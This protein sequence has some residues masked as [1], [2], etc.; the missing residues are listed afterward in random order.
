MSIIKR[1]ADK[2]GIKE[3]CAFLESPWFSIMYGV[4]VFW[5]YALN[6]PIVTLGIFA[7]CG[8][9]VCLFCEDTRAG[10]TLLL[11]TIFSFRYK[12]NPQIYISTPA[13][14]LYAVAGPCLLFAIG[15]RLLKRRVPFKSRYGLLGVALFTAAMLLGGVFTEYYTFWGFA[16]ATALSAG[17]FLSYAFFAFTLKNKED[18]L[19]YLA[20]V[21]TVGVCL[22]S[23]EVFEFYL[24][25]YR[26]GSPLDGGWKGLICLG[27]AM[28]NMVSE[29]IVFAL[30]AVFYL[31]YKEDRG[32]W[33]WLVVLIALVAIYLML[34]RNALLGAVVCVCLGTLANCL[35]GKN[36]TKNRILVGLFLLLAIGGLIGLHHMGYIEDLLS[37][38]MKMGLSDNGRFS[39]WSR[40]IGFFKE[41]PIF[42]AGFDAY[43]QYSDRVSRAHNNLLQMLGSTGIV[44]LIMYLI[45]RVQTVGMI[46]KK[47]T[48]DRLLMGGCIGIS[49][50]MAMLSSTFFHIYS[51]IHYAVILLVLE[52]SGEK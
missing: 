18:N 9:F 36:R 20:R 24:R 3:L 7:V 17:L 4:V 10:I 23:L 22:I 14:I 43:K 29:M 27:W 6:I 47:P 50:M 46:L 35:T 34:G 45:H 39:V 26:W 33:Y 19:L 16:K 21:L 2:K 49:L 41:N 48:V 37:F 38:F 44:G 40:F 28:N 25:N 15:Y 52:K 1:I 5:L 13:I 8:I 30:P 32:C 31:I 42:G 12:D 51:I 11:L